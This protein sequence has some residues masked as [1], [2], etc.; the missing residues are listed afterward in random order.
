MEEKII[1]VNAEDSQKRIDKF[2][3]EKLE[4]KS[5]SYIQKLLE[6]GSITVDD[7]EVQNSYRIKENELIRIK[8]KKN[9]K[10]DIKPAAMDLDIIYEDKDILVLNKKAGIVVHPAPGHYD[11]TI[12]NALMAYT[13]DLSG[14]NG[15]K[16]PGIVHRLDMDTSGVLIVAK[17]DHSHKS[18]VEQFKMRETQKYYLA[19]LKGNIP[20]QKGKID[21]PIGRDPSSRKKM[22][23]RK[24]HSKKAI[25][26]F[27]I[28]EE[29]KNHTLVEVKIET[30]RTHQIR[31]HFSYMGYPVAG[32]KKYGN[33]EEKLSIN[34]QML[35]AYRLII[36][37][38]VSEKKMEFKAELPDDFSDILKKL[39]N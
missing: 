22:A 15:V 35:H 1:T 28:K 25:S 14:I 20:Y 12:V 19:L 13:D 30:G 32:D 36:T 37:H 8:I 34:R 33:G 7:K 27:K 21:A 4:G 11:D 2:L 23:V 10:A 26:H 18:L 6:N 31:V 5:R 29:F 3:A 38:P 17:N 16:R 39:R 24:R 9:K